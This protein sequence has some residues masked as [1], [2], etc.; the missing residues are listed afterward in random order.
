MRRADCGDIAKLP[1]LIAAP[2]TMSDEVITARC[3][4][5]LVQP[6][7]RHGYPAPAVGLPPSIGLFP[8]RYIAGG[9]GRPV[10]TNGRKVAA[11]RG[12]AANADQ[13]ITVRCG[14]FFWST[15]ARGMELPSTAIAL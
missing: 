8:L 13:V 12:L 7:C 15:V 6:S 14:I 9:D 4:I 3:A 2:M 5:F 1:E 10:C 11:F